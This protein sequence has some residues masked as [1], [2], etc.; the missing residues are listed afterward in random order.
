[1]TLTATINGIAGGAAPSGTATFND[2]INGGAA[3]VLGSAAANGSAIY[4]TFALGAGAHSLT[5]GYGGDANYVTSTSG[6]IAVTVVPVGI[7]SLNPVSLNYSS[8]PI[9]V[10]SMAMPITLT[11]IGVA[12]LAISNLQ[13]TGDNSTDFSVSSSACGASL[14]QGLL[15]V[16]VCRRPPA[17][18]PRRWSSPTT[19]TASADRCSPSAWSARR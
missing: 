5:V 2:A 11:N 14:V 12:N 18:A 13:I 6:A 1:M 19:T 16:N 8:Q 17:R 7:A 4:N 10:A 3:S 9:G 15:V